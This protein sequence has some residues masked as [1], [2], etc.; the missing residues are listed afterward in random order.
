MHGIKRVRKQVTIILFI[1]CHFVSVSAQKP[2]LIEVEAAH[3]FTALGS[4]AGLAYDV[5]SGLSFGVFFSKVL[6]E[7][8]TA[9]FTLKTGLSFENRGAGV[10]SRFIDQNG[11]NIREG[12]VYSKFNY[13]TVPVLIELYPFRKKIL[14][15][16]AGF[17]FSYLAKHYFTEFLYREGS[18]SESGE[19]QDFRPSQPSQFKSYDIGFRFG[20]GIKIN[21]SERSKLKMI[22]H[23]S[24]GFTNILDD[25]Q[26][27]GKT[28]KHLFQA[29]SL[30]YGYSF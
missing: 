24:Q 25:P 30:S 11:S 7:E 6:Y 27:E 29:F 14:F 28:M 23:V 21:L 17:Y 20:I 15:M 22:T 1:F 4:N 5:S 8:K 18:Y 19:L 16:E 3:L 9:L 2:G 26:F 13:L 10:I 12:Y